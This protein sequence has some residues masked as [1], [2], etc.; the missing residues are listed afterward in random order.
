VYQNPNSNPDGIAT[1]AAKTT[2]YSKLRA[3]TCNLLQAQKK[4]FEQ[5]T[6]GLA[7]NS[8]WLRKWREFP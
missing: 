8:E 6:I 7:F 2:D 4:A 3:V 5:V 1:V